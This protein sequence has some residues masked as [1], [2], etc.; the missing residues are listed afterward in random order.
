L[1]LVLGAIP[2]RADTPAGE[3]VY[4][5]SLGSADDIRVLLKQGASANQTNN[6]GVPVLCLAAA[7]SDK[8]GIEVAKALLAGG[9]DIN[10]TD[11]NG[12][13]ALFYAAR[14]GNLPMVNFL[15]EHG[16]K[17]YA[18]D[19]DDTIAR[20]VAF[21]NGYTDIVKAMDDFVKA[22]TKKVEE[23]YKKAYALIAERKKQEQEK[24]EKLRKAAETPSPASPPVDK[25]VEARKAENMERLAQ[26]LSYHACEFQ[27]W[28]F[29]GAVKQESELSPDELDIA[30]DTHKKQV[31]AIEKTLADEYGKQPKFVADIV[32]SAEKRIFNQLSGLDTNFSRHE[33]G[34]G[35]M[36][37][38]ESRCQ[39]IA[40]DWNID[41]V[42]I[43]TEGQGQV[44]NAIGGGIG[45]VTGGTGGGAIGSPGNPGSIPPA[46]RQHP[47]QITPIKPLR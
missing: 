18:E 37:D 5:A 32:N 14:N 45:G 34:V 33:K 15:L 9:A 8:E 24:A 41:P 12:Q 38:A 7:R 20:T 4:R 25:A 17:Y 26:G 29:L 47:Q 19:K 44:G 39:H 22:Q 3:M 46:V 16:I 35:K 40:R 36:D 31:E 43:P 11:K 10:G 27:Y 6:I 28:Y 30:V 21:D 2:A 42:T 23:D 13:T 1:A